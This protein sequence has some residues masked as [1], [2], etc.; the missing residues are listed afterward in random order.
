MLLNEFLKQHRKVEEQS[1][2]V[3]ELKRNIAELKKIVSRL[4]E[5]NK[6]AADEAP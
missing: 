2:E 3:Q 5:N 6:P 4:S 1:A